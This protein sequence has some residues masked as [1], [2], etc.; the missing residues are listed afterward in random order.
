M[1]LQTQ[2]TVPKKDLRDLEYFN[3]AEVF[4]GTFNRECQDYPTKEDCLVFCN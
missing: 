1:K 4:E 2:F 3:K